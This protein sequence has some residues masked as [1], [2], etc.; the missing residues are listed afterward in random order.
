MALMRSVLGASVVVASLALAGCGNS[1]PTTDPNVIGVGITGTLT[2]IGA[3]QTSQLA[4]FAELIDGE[5][6]TVTTSAAWAS[7]DPTIA[8]V[9]AT[10][11]VTTVSFGQVTI[12]ATFGGV[13]ATATF[14]SVPNFAGTWGAS[15]AKDTGTLT[16]TLALGQSGTMSSGSFMSV[17]TGDEPFNYTGQFSGTIA[18]VTLA[19]TLTI[20]AATCAGII[21]GT[22]TVSGN[23]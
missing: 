8:T 3:G 9:S 23:G 17:R 14:V 10:G 6:L 12:T 16:L 22:A 4:A 2:L 21:N 5:T 7:T 18:G 20:N 11:L 13:Q 15:A 19:W 1:T